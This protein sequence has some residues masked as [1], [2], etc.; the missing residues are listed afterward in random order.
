MHAYQLLMR[1]FLLRFIPTML[2][3]GPS[4]SSLLPIVG[5]DS[6]KP[7]RC[8]DRTL[9]IAVAFPRSR[10]WRRSDIPRGA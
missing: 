10:R 7:D 2:P 9:G 1:R 8:D 6:K 4:I 3:S 5:D